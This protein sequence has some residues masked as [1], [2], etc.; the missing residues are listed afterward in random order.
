MKKFGPYL[1]ETDLPHN[2]TVADVNWWTQNY[3]GG[4]V[5][6]K[7]LSKTLHRYGPSL[8]IRPIY[9]RRRVPEY[10]PFGKTPDFVNINVLKGENP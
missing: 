7:G 6:D 4:F 2:L 10:V 1:M 9:G 5:I 3:W 8:A